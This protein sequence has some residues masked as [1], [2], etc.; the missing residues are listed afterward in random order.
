MSTANV[1]INCLVSALLKTVPEKGDYS[2]LTISVSR[3][4]FIL[5]F[6]IN[7]IVDL[8]YVTFTCEDV[9]NILCCLVY[10]MISDETSMQICNYIFQF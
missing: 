4:F 1:L 10:L 2:A 9:M 3:D 7:C 5:V 8:L 6:I